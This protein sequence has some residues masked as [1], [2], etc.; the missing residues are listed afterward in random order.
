VTRPA[1]LI[2]RGFFV[3][4]G[5][6]YDKFGNDFIIRGVNNPHVWFDIGDQY[7]AYG[8]LD[9]IAARGVNTIRI[10]WETTGTAALLRRVIRRVVELRMIPMVELHD[11]TGNA[12]N[13]RLLA[14]AA[15]FATPAVKQVLLDYEDFL[16]VNIA[17]EWNGTDYLNGYQAAI[18]ELRRNG[19][20]HT[21]V[22]DA[23]GFG[24]NA[25]SILT[26]GTTLTTRDPQ[27]NLLFSVHMYDAYS[28]ARGGGPP[29]ITQTLEQAAA[30]SLPLIVGEF[31]W[32]GGIP[33]VP[34][35]AAFIMSECQRLRL[36]YLAWS[37]KGND[38][39]L[40]YLDMTVDWEGVQLN[41]WGN[42]IFQGAAGITMSATRATIYTP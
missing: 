8:A 2:S 22:I 26:D 4:R 16:L 25:A 19:I 35:D 33:P 31:G 34:I 28:A 9:N 29:R 24:Q 42:T 12:D 18:A 14:M 10:V 41:P 5:R 30:A 23:N 11:V 13:A 32:Q 37:W 40:A 17:N 3:T 7:L 15:Y 36:G 6:L 1:G 39:S 21:L 27:H 20:N 38:P